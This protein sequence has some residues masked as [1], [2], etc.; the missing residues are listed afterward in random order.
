MWHRWL[1]PKKKNITP[2]AYEFVVS[3]QTDVGCRRESNEDAGRCVKPHDPELLSN[4]GVLVMVADGMGGYAAGEVA[5][6]LAVDVI[7]R[8]YYEEKVTAPVALKKA[9]EQA[10]RAIYEQARKDETLKGMGTTCTALVLQNRSA[11]A[12]HVGDS[13]LYLVR[14]DAIYQQ[15]EDHSAVREMVKRG[16]LSVAEA[17]RH[18]ERN[19]LVRAMGRHPNVEVVVWEEPLSVCAGDRFLLC[20]DGLHDLVT[21]EEM[22]QAVLDNDPPAACER[23]IALAKQR[24]GHDNITVGV[25][26]VQPV[27]EDAPVNMPKTRQVEVRL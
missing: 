21:D 19:V 12:A 17:Q 6:R 4:K 11:F 26:Q 14:D 25:V 22:K 8:A 2:L 27:G 20:S 5:S 9:F 7:S 13:R 16:L 15:T 24:G 23:L 3:V 1:K 18:P 10:N